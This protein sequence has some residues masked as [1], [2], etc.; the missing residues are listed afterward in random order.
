MVSDEEA[1]RYMFPT[2]TPN[3]LPHYLVA[4]SIHTASVRVSR[5]WRHVL[6]FWFLIIVSYV[7]A[8]NCPHAAFANL[9]ESVNVS[10][11]PLFAGRIAEAV[12]N[13]GKR[14]TGFDELSS[15]KRVT[16]NDTPLPWYSVCAT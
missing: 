5:V 1:D 7:S 16:T 12:R 9:F 10:C 15:G 2:W 3:S 6:E 13:T 11:G 8:R 14:P 4:C